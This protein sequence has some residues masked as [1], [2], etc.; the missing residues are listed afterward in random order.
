MGWILPQYNGDDSIHYITHSTVKSWF[1]LFLPQAFLVTRTWGGFSFEAVWSIRLF[2]MILQQWVQV[3]ISCT[4][5]ETSSLFRL[6]FLESMK[7]WQPSSAGAFLLQAWVSGLEVIPAQLWTGK[8][9]HLTFQKFSQF[10][11]R[12]FSDT[13]ARFCSAFSSH[14]LPTSVDPQ[15][16]M[17][18]LLLDGLG[19]RYYH[20]PTCVLDMEIF[21]ISD[22]GYRSA[23]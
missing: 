16:S 10:A 1:G 18:I 5:K 7:A 22:N 2:L 21:Q 17:H 13:L 12:G 20:L 4:W 19:N 23:R 6:A 3:H 14:D 11:L 9:L 15:D 8:W